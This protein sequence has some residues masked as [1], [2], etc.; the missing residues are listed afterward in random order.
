MFKDI[1]LPILL[2]IGGFFYL[3]WLYKSNGNRIVFLIKKTIH[4]E[5]FKP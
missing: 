5:K 3:K 2:I 1:I 4:L